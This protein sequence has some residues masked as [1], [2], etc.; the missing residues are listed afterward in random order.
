MTLDLFAH[1]ALEEPSRAL[2]AAQ[3]DADLARVLLDTLE[4]SNGQLDQALRRFYADH[5]VGLERR[6]I[7]EPLGARHAHEIARHL[8]RLGAAA[9]VPDASLAVTRGDRAEIE[10]VLRQMAHLAA[11]P[12]A[13]APLG[14]ELTAVLARAEHRH[15]DPGAAAEARV[16]AILASDD[17]QVLAEAALEVCTGPAPTPL[18]VRYERD[19]PEISCPAF[20]LITPEDG[21]RIDGVELALDGDVLDLADACADA[22]AQIDPGSDVHVPSTFADDAQALGA[23]ARRLHEQ[24]DAGL[25]LVRV[26]R[27]Y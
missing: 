8:E 25:V 12:E 5:G 14:E 23:F 4:E 13:V 21:V 7:G 9:L 22:A 16:R 24:G 19:T 27:L 18:H 17:L 3:V 11:V 15:R 6:R 26:R 2:R 1:P 20:V 10:W